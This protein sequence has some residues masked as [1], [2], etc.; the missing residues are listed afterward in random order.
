MRSIGSFE[1]RRVILR[2]NEK[3]L[4]IQIYKY[5]IIFEITLELLLSFSYLFDRLLN[6]GSSSSTA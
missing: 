5:N 2:L 1:S 3:K 6:H 4:L